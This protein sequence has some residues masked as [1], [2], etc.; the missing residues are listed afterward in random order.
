MSRTNTKLTF[1]VEDSVIFHLPP[2][3]PIPQDP[4]SL[5]EEIGGFGGESGWRTYYPEL[6]NKLTQMNTHMNK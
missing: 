4:P 5:F 3:P 6:S 1:H 2:K